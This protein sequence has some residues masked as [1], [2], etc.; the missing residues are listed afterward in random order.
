MSKCLEFISKLKIPKDIEEEAHNNSR[1]FGVIDVVITAGISNMRRMN[2]TRDKDKKIAPLFL[3]EPQRL[4][5][6]GAIGTQGIRCFVDADAK[7]RSKE[8]GLT[9]QLTTRTTKEQSQEKLGFEVTQFLYDTKN[10]MQISFNGNG[11]ADVPLL[12]KDI[13]PGFPVRR[14]EDAERSIKLRHSNLVVE[15][16]TAAAKDREKRGAN[17]GKRLVGSKIVKLKIGKAAASMIT[18]TSKDI[19]KDIVLPKSKI[20]PSKILRLKFTKTDALKAILTSEASSRGER[21]SLQGE[22]KTPE[23]RKSDGEESPVPSKKAKFDGGKKEGLI[24]VQN[25]STPLNETE[26]TRANEVERTEILVPIFT[27][28]SEEN[29]PK[30]ILKE[31]ASQTFKIE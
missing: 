25:S 14:L 4:L 20:V 19:L 24:K 7:P 27:S 30:E 21:G 2:L 3:Q 29:P 5:S 17:V 8:L 16:D 28:T 15:K 22:D 13:D 26:A 11:I 12:H 18:P 23:K 6:K 1:K 10:A 31:V 9:T